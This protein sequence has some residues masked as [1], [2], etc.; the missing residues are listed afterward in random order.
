MTFSQK[1]NTSQSGVAVG[2]YDRR[3]REKKI[4]KEQILAVAQRSFFR[5][6]Y[7]NTTIELIAKKLEVSKG[8]IYLYYKSKDDLYAALMMPVIEEFSKKLFDFET[9]LEKKAY[10]TCNQFFMELFQVFYEVYKLHPDGVKV[11]QIFQVGNLFPEMSED[12]LKKLNDRGSENRATLRRILS[13]A[14][15]LGIMREMDTAKLGDVIWGL[16]V[17]LLQIEESKLRWTGKDHLQDTLE[18]SFSLISGA[19]SQT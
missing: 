1:L 19:V 7:K 10:G 2:T 17:G 6:G 12:T 9:D 13:K 15:K 5:K 4:R 8:T 18:F 16:F 3:E 14:V 11:I